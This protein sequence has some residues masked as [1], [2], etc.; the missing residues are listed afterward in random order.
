VLTIVEPVRRAPGD[1]QIRRGFPLGDTEITRTV[2]T[3]LGAPAWQRTPLPVIGQVD[4]HFMP[5][6]MAGAAVRFPIACTTGD[7]VVKLDMPM[8]FVKDWRPD[9]ESLTS[10]AL[11][12]RLATDYGEPEIRIAPAH[13]DLVGAA[14]QRAAGD[15]HE[16]RA[17]KIGGA[18]PGDGL[19]LADGYR[20]K[21]TQLEIGLPALRALRGDERATRVKFADKYL[22]HGA[23]EDVLLEMLPDNVVPNNTVPID[24]S[25]SADRSGG[26]VAPKYVT[27]AVSRSMG[28]VDR[29]ALP[30]PATGF[31]DPERRTARVYTSVEEYT[32]IKES[33]V[34]DGGEVLPG[35][36]IKLKDLFTRVPRE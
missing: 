32:E 11:A 14:E 3:G 33:G 12:E 13:I 31:I 20:P 15:V 29:F 4:T 5:T 25:R 22:R 17:V 19:N 26:L 35:F 6:T 34:L 36:R 24:F 27:N 9:A 2:F 28:L 30:N 21:L 7:R 10:P 8:L 23:A 16:V 18:K 1:G